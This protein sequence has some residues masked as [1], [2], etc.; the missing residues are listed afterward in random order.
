MAA[1]FSFV[2]VDRNRVERLSREG[3]P[4]ARAVERILHRLSF[5]LSGTQLGVTVCSLVLGFIAQPTVATVLEPALGEGPS[6]IVGLAL[7]TVVSMVVSELIPKNVSIARAERI[8]MLLARPIVFYAALFGP[9]IRVLNRSANATVRRLGIEPQQELGSVRTLEE[10]ELLIRSSGEEG[11][12]DAEAFTLLTRTLRFNDKT[13]ADALVPRVDVK[14]VHPDDTIPTLISR[15][16][17]T[18][19]SRFPVCGTDLDDVVGVVHVKD[20]YRLPVDRRA[21]ATVADVMTDPFVVPET[22]DLAS[23]LVDLRTGSHLAIVVDEYGGTAG[24]ITLEDVLE[25]IVGEIDD[26]YDRA[27]PP[28]T[29]VLPEGTYELPGTLHPDEVREACGLEIPEGEYETLAGFVLDRLGRIPTEGDAFVYEGW[30]IE[31]AEMDR[32]R[33]ARVRLTAPRRAHADAEANR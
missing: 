31:V 3:R 28:L 29:T 24:I 14:Y 22:R 33:I 18:G 15:S 20:V 27:A 5:Y 21:E 9:V 4:S 1:E 17:E 12:L 10:L 13:A 7:V 8:S 11:T 26:E 30:R 23:L 16:L 2:A 25:E 6:I 32:R 19:F